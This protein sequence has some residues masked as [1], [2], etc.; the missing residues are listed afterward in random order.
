MSIKHLTQPSLA[1]GLVHNHRHLRELDDIQSLIDWSEIAQVLNAIEIKDTGNRAYTSLL[2]FKIILLQTWYNLSDVQMEK[3]MAR[4]LMFRRFTALPL[5]APTPDHSTIWRFREK[6]V[7]LQ[8]HKPLL[9][10]INVQLHHKRIKIKQ[11]SV[12]IIDATLIK[13]HYGQDDEATWAT[14]TNSKGKTESTY[15]YK[16]HINVDEDGFVNSHT[17]NTAAPHDSQVFGE[18]IVEG[19]QALYGDCAFQSAKHDELLQTLGIDNRMHEK[20]QRNKPLTEQ[21]KQNNRIRSTIRN[22]VERVYGQTKRHMGLGIAK[23][24]GKARNALR[25]GMIYLCHNLKTARRF[26]ATP[27]PKS[28]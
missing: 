1:D 20:A 17:Y 5:D 12:A 22:T 7:K 4:D 18:L 27:H 23:Y 8:L 19:N 13:A 2:M 9:D 3:Q 16:S 26:M 24:Q 6:L 25:A 28:V 14:K 15:G 10:N 11:G 21:Q